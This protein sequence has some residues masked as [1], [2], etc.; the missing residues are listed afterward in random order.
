MTHSNAPLSIEGRRRLVERC[1]IRPIA[2]PRLRGSPRCLTL[3]RQH[4]LPY[5]SDPSALGGVRPIVTCCS[6]TGYSGPTCPSSRLRPSH[7]V[8]RSSPGIA[9]LWVGGD[10]PAVF[11]GEDGDDDGGGDWVEHNRSYDEGQTV[12]L[13]VCT[14]DHPDAACSAK[15][16]Y[17][18]VS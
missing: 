14:S 9:K 4:E 5:A 8:H 10:G 12:Y 18:G 16:K 1:K 6:G 2:S 15:E 3:K 17:S 11:Y 7:R 13:Q